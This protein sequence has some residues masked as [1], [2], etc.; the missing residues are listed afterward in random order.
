[1]KAWL[2]VV[3]EVEGTRA[4]ILEWKSDEAEGRVSR[5]TGKIGCLK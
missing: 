5:G 3:G 4:E 1:M 2:G